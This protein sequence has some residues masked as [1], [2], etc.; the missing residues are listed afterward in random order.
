MTILLLYNYP[1]YSLELLEEKTLD[2]VDVG[3]VWCW[4]KKMRRY[5][6]NHPMETV[7][8]LSAADVFNMVAIFSRG[9]VPRT[10]ATL[11]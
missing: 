9:R 8:F 5:R 10:G 2:T 4:E 3:D 6:T 1:E 7:L 11:S